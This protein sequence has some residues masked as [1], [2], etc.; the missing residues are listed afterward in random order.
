PQDGE[1]R[2]RP[3]ARVGEQA[4]QLVD[5]GDRL[6]VERDQQ[7]PF[8]ETGALRRAVLLDPGDQDAGVARQAVVTD[9]AALQRYVLPGH[10]DVS[11]ADGAVLDQAA[12]DELHR[13]D[14]DGEADSLRRQDDRRVDAD[15]LS[16]RVDQRPARIPGVERGIR[17]D[18][19]VDQTARRRAQRP[20]Q[21]ADHARGD[22]ALEA[23]RVADRHDQL[24][25]A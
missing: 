15:D 16:R 9:Q 19:V 8:L 4:V 25:R 17:L 2:P 24:P 5:A 12:G 6:A 13:V 7:V 3:D 14:G 23:V 20:T 22:G 10:A 11:A 1:C 18:D 21:G